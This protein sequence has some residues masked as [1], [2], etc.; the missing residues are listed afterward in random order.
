MEQ[1]RMVTLLMAGIS[2]PKDFLK[3]LKNTQNFPITFFN[4]FGRFLK[5]IGNFQKLVENFLKTIFTI[6]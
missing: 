1:R 4:N 3:I 5:I 2:T 6:P